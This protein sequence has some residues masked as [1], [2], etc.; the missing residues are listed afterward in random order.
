MKFAIVI[1]VLEFPEMYEH[2][3]KLEAYIGRP[4]TRLKAE[5]SFEYYFYDYHPVR[6][7]S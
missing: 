2:I 6:K 5:H 7:K 3:D 1:R 4:I